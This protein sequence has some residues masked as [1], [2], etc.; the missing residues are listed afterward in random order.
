MKNH[1]ESQV[2]VLEV[3]RPTEPLFPYVDRMDQS[4]QTLLRSSQLE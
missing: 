1:E 4:T 3:L 2:Q